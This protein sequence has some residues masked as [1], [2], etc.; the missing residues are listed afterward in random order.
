MAA[1]PEG[2]CGVL[3]RRFGGAGLPGETEG[4]VG[5]L[6]GQG[7]TLPD[8]SGFQIVAQKKMTRALLLKFGRNAG[9]STITVRPPAFPPSP[10]ALHTPTPSHRGSGTPV[11]EVSG[12]RPEVA[13]GP[14][15][16]RQAWRV[17]P[18]ALASPQVVAEDISGNNG[19]VELSFRARKLDDKVSGAARVGP[20]PPWRRQGPTPTSALPN[21]SPRPRDSTDAGVVLA[22]GVQTWPERG[23]AWAWRSQ[24]GCWGASEGS[25]GEARLWGHSERLLAGPALT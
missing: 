14:S 24:Q 16:S 8:C 19:Y 12:A 23:W 6:R 10:S 7:L 21:R 25:R 2:G 9:K 15:A 3:G 18:R 4:R 11:L 20:R 13:G 1:C 5:V 22:G 17:E